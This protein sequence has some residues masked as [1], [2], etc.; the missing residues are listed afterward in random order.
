MDRTNIFS[1]KKFQIEIF[2][3]SPGLLGAVH[4]VEGA[5]GPESFAFDMLGEGPCTGVSDGRIIKWQQN[6]R[7]WINFAVTSPKR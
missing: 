6:E 7:R 1:S 3:Q 5:I 4:Q 2:R